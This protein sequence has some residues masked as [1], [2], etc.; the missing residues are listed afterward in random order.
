[1]IAKTKVVKQNTSDSA[2]R[3]ESQETDSKDIVLLKSGSKDFRVPTRLGLDG[4]GY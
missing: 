4:C 1:M 2:S 3:Q